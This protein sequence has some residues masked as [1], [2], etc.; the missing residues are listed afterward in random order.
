MIN[1][2]L[3]I[4]DV[5]YSKIAS[6]QKQLLNTTI[7]KYRRKNNNFTAP[8]AKKNKNRRNVVKR[9]HK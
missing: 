7:K 3:N 1:E 2:L 6:T 9:K 5:D 4:L 8:K